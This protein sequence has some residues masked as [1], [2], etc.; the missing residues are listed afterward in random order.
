MQLIRARATPDLRP[1]GG[2]SLFIFAFNTTITLVFI[3]ASACKISTKCIIYVYRMYIVS[4]VNCTPV[5][6][7]N[8]IMRVGVYRSCADNIHCHLH[9]SGIKNYTIFERRFVCD[10]LKFSI[11]QPKNSECKNSFIKLLLEKAALM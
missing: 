9:V 2:F 4:T 1:T 6:V 11:T 7:C 10:R 5:R 8:A 3:R